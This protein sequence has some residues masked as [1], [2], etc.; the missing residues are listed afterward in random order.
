M[1]LVENRG[2]QPKTFWVKLR[3]KKLVGSRLLKEIADSAVA[4]GVIG[5][6]SPHKDSKTLSE[7][8]WVIT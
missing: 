7:I 8:I 1:A 6:L 5:G 2:K 4:Y 3:L